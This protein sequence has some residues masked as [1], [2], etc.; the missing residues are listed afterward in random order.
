MSTTRSDGAP[1][2][3][4]AS[5]QKLKLRSG[6]ASASVSDEHSRTER[7]KERSLSASQMFAAPPIQD[8]A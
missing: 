4:K 2:I 8:A 5:G 1:K 3:S 6:V 7:S